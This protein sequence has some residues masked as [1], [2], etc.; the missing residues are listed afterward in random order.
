M[1]IVQNVRGR[2]LYSEKIL[3]HSFILRATPVNSFLHVLL[4]IVYEFVRIYVLFPSTQIL[5]YYKH[6]S[7]HDFYHLTGYLGNPSTSEHTYFLRTGT[8]YLYFNI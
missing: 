8:M 4:E 6:F 7:E 2:W 5:E 1:L 3:S